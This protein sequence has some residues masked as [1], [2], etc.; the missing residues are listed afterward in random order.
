MSHKSVIIRLGAVVAL[1]AGLAVAAVAAP[2]A[3]GAKTTPAVGSAVVGA[4]GGAH[5]SLPASPATLHTFLAG[6]E[7]LTPSGLTSATTKFRIPTVTCPSDDEM[8]FGWGVYAIPP[9]GDLTF[10]TQADVQ[11]V[12]ESGAVQFY[13]LQAYTPSNQQNDA[14]DASPGDLVIATI[15]EDGTTTTSTLYDVT[16]NVTMTAV[17][18]TP[19]DTAELTGS[20]NYCY[21]GVNCGTGVIPSFGRVTLNKSRVNGEVIGNTATSR[22]N[23]EDGSDVQASATNLNHTGDGFGVIFRHSA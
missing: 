16:K 12:C 13:D 6:W 15:T 2:A 8:D 11:V 9:A 19:F 23:M 20:Y 17:D 7:S 22:L 21:D 4:A 14:T 3:S 18:S 1:T 5:R 10:T